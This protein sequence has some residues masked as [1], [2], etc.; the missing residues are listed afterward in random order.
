MIKR[1]FLFAALL[2]IPFQN[3]N[4]T[5]NRTAKTFMATRPI[6]QN[7]NASQFLF[8]D[9]IYSDKN[10]LIQ[11]T[12]LYQKSMAYAANK[13]YFLINNK[14]SLRIKGSNYE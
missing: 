11:I 7:I 2:L 9:A 10:S 5:D 8:H 13:E 3:T 14:Q 4:T 1:R 12:P 6:Y